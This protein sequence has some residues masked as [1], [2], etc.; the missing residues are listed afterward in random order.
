ME[1]TIKETTEQLQNGTIKFY[2]VYLV[3]V[4]VLLVEKILTNKHTL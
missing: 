2:W 1:N 4:V 3:L